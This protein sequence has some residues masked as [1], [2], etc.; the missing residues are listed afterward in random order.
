MIKTILIASVVF[1]AGYVIGVNVHTKRI[2]KKLEK[3]NA[4]LNTIKE[5]NN[6][7]LTNFSNL[8]GEVNGTQGQFTEMDERIMGMWMD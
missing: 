7:F 3:C 6:Q 2:D 1:I 5:K 8:Y 4:L